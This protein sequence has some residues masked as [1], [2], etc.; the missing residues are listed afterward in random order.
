MVKIRSATLL[1]H[2]W[3]K[4]IGNAL[5]NLTL[6]GFTRV[7]VSIN[8]VDYCMDFLNARVEIDPKDFV[9][10]ARVTKSVYSSVSDAGIDGF[11]SIVRA[12]HVE[13][14]TLGKMPNKQVI[15]YDKRREV[16]SKKKL[17]WF[18]AW[19]IDKNDTTQSVLR[20]ELRAGKNELK[21]FN[22]KTLEDLYERIGDVLR[23]IIETIRHR[24]TT[25]NE[26]QHNTFTT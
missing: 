8:R 21:K 6:I 18:D 24:A 22:I 19:S 4:A 10:H 7:D 1:L 3:K 9:A 25:Q 17:Y 12:D 16:I 23:S 26:C 2:G 11:R 20:V 15:V 5:H 13:S 14:V